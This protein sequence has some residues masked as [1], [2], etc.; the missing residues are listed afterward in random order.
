MCPEHLHF[1]PVIKKDVDKDTMESRGV[2]YSIV[3]AKLG[4]FCEDAKVILPKCNDRNLLKGN[5][6][7]FLLF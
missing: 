4:Y 2:I 7:T 5:F 3:K 6:V 1:S